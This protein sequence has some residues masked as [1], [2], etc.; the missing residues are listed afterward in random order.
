MKCHWKKWY[1]LGFTDKSGLLNDLWL[2][3]DIS[4]LLDEYVDVTFHR[5]SSFN[6]TRDRFER[7]KFILPLTFFLKSDEKSSRLLL[8]SPTS[9]TTLTPSVAESRNVVGRRDVNKEYDVTFIFWNDVRKEKQNNWEKSLDP[10][11]NIF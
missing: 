10:F 9:T 5:L 7:D 8:F 6:E 11:I 2:K 4:A 1:S 3:S